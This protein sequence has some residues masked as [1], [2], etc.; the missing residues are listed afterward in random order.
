M[1]AAELSRR[2]GLGRVE[3]LSDGP[4]ARGKQ[5]VVWR[6]DTSSGRWAV[7]QLLQRTSEDEARLSAELQEAAY[8]A[9]VPRVAS[10][11]WLQPNPRSP[12]RADS[13]AWVGEMFDDPHTR[14]PLRAS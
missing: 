8:L 14:T 12:E 4:A 11:D 10:L 7:K 6:L 9:G 5:G 1:D 13:E 2:Y 3:R